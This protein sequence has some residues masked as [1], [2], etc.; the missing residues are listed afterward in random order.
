MICRTM[1]EHWMVVVLTTAC[2]AVLFGAM[3]GAF[4]GR[5]NRA[6]QFW[7][8]HPWIVFWMLAALACLG[9]LVLRFASHPPRLAG[10]VLLVLALLALFPTAAWALWVSGSRSRRR[11][12]VIVTGGFGALVVVLQGAHVVRTGRLSNV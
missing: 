2:F 1:T 4:A 8:T 9:L 5:A 7:T 11:A 6:A 12:R 3:A 10:V